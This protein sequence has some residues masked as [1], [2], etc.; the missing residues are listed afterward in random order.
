MGDY[1]EQARRLVEGLK[2]GGQGKV[3]M[4]PG[5]EGHEKGGQ[6][7]EVHR[8]GN[9]VPRLEQL[10]RL[11]RNGRRLT[12]E[13]S[14]ELHDLELAERAKFFEA[15]ERCQR[16]DGST[17]GTRGKCR[18]GTPVAANTIDALR[19]RFETAKQEAKVAAK[20]VEAKG[21]A[22]ATPE[23]R[24]RLIEA[25]RK[26]NEVNTTLEKAEWDRKADERETQAAAD[27]AKQQKPGEPAATK[28]LT[29]EQVMKAVGTV[30]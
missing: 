12:A 16:K 1:S 18:K 26:L 2:K 29:R 20:A 11:K 19:K 10:R 13:D 15:A 8:E 23:E 17:Y 22:N 5:T 28:E 3:P 4:G 25:W 14:L 24:K 27:R 7:E 6:F 9:R 21:G 30:D